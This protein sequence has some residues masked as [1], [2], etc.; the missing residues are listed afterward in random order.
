MS[1]PGSSST[2]IADLIPLVQRNLQN[3]QDVTESQPNAEMRPSAWLRDALKEITSRWPFEELRQP[4]PPLVT[5]GPGL[6]V[7]GSSYKYPVSIFLNPG[8]DVTLQE[9]PVIFLNSMQSV[10]MT[11]GTL[12][13]VAYPMDYMTPK[14]IATL[15]NVPGGIPSKYTR[16]GTQFW[17][18]VQPNQ[19]FVVYLPYQIRHDFVP[20][21]LP[22]STAKIP[23]DW[24]EIVAMA[25]AERGAIAL[26]WNEQASFLHKELY[27]DP[28]AGTATDGTLNR[29][30]LIAAK[31]LQPE[32]DKR[33][34][35]SQITPFAQRY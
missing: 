14:A 13:A 23:P 16:Y 18:G 33:L 6:G 5:I 21:N 9:D 34:S 27:G 2:K 31:T 22:A 12:G 28:S 7:G 25:A 3:R 11:P 32:K 17:F 4:N 19:N 10:A 29:P 26:R 8:D 1:S 24:H 30:G 20:G 35:P 15:L